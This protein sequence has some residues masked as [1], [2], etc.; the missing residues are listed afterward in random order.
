M[1][2]TQ[3]RHVDPDVFRPVRPAE[4]GWWSRLL[5]GAH[6]WGSYDAA[7]GRH[8]VR[9]YRL[10]VYPPGTNVTLQRL[11]RLWREWPITGAAIILLAVILLGNVVAA[12]ETVLAIAVTAYVGVGAL[13]VLRAGPAR[14][15][16]RSMSI[17]LTPGSTDPRDG[18]RYL[19]WQSLAQMLTRADRA[20]TAGAISPVEHEAIWWHAY[21]RLAAANG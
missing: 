20:L 2:R 10:I 16:V 1:R 6:P 13:L 5:D 11:A 3:N 4:P 12:P 9:R 21:D 7:V 15:P 18:R 19:E 14:V 17:V 8:G